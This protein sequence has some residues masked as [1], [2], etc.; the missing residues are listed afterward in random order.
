MGDRCFIPIDRKNRNHERKAFSRKSQAERRRFTDAISLPNRYSLNPVNR[1][2][3]D[4]Q[5]AASLVRIQARHNRIN[6]K[7][8]VFQ[9]AASV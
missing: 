7:S 9:F 5:A 2:N 3:P 4:N 6:P 1:F 8:V